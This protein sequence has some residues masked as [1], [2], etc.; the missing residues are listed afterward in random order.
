MIENGIK[1]GHRSLFVIVGDKGK[2]QVVIL[3]E[4]LSKAVVKAR[5]SV[6]WCYKKELEFSSHRKKKMKSLKKKIKHGKIDVNE[7][8]PFEL[9]VVSTNIRY[10]YYKETHKIL[11]STYG[12]AILQV[13]I[14]ILC[15][16]SA[17]TKAVLKIYRFL[18]WEF[19]DFWIAH[20]FEHFDSY[21]F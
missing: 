19:F 8:D 15:H 6:L 2:D 1:L 18:F 12:M 17:F 21:Q 16:L 13:E 9:F 5:P 11:G 7:D 20:N 14:M 4:M 10:C 3:H